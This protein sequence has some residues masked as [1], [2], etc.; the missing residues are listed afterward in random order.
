[1]QLTRRSLAA[2]GA[3]AAA[4]LIAPGAAQADP[5]RWHLAA[6]DDFRHG[7]RNWTA[8]LENGGT[9]EARRGKLVVDVPAGATI[10]YRHLL[11]GPYAVEYTAVPVGAGG[12]NDRVSD[13]NTFWGARDARSP[14][15]VF[16]TARSGAL[17]EYDH[18]KAYYVGFGGNYNATTRFRRYV[19]EPGNRPLIYD[20]TEPVLTANEPHRVRQVVDGG[21]IQYWING[22]LLFD[23]TDPEPYD[24]GWFALRT[25][26][27][28]L[29]VGGFKVWRRRP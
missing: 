25:T 24:S 17:A 9:V 23:Y 16:A 27:S 14:D 19:G 28:H 10:W 18:L 3:G 21:R 26:W 11:K 4:A 5:G 12:P 29:E 20:R 6:R 1:M 15:D 2:L 8:E 7:L 13:L 22:S